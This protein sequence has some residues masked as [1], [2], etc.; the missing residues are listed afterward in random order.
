MISWL[1]SKF[2]RNY[3]H[4]RTYI[5][6]HQSNFLKGKIIKASQNSEVLHE[7][8]KIKTGK[9]SMYSALFQAYQC[10]NSLNLIQ[11]LLHFT[12]E[13]TGKE[14][15]YDLSNGITFIKDSDQLI[16]HIVH[17]SII[18]SYI[19]IS[20]LQS[21]PESKA[22]VLNMRSMSSLKQYTE[23][24]VQ[25][26]NAFFC[27]GSGQVGKG[28]VASMRFSKGSVTPKRSVIWNINNETVL[29]FLNR[30]KIMQFEFQT[31]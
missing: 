13:E 27:V 25:M 26:H 17:F 8:I 14:R 6:T 1:L 19:S 31:L 10:T 29:H 4:T 16:L 9:H 24:S 7:I 2:L 21:L 20:K 3:T 5:H 23:L 15:L 11:Q 30:H 22:E 18:S 28:E 12:D